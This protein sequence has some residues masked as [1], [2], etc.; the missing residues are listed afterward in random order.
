MPAYA[1]RS[2]MGRSGRRRTACLAAGAVFGALF[3]AAS[4]WAGEPT[5]FT[6]PYAGFNVGYGLGT[7]HERG[8]TAPAPS[9]G[10]GSSTDPSLPPSAAAA[11]RA[12]RSMVRG[13]GP[14]R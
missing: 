7:A 6:G 1:P 3:L 11:V 9:L 5:D 4:A 13:N 14:G 2:V 10:R 8:T 12:M